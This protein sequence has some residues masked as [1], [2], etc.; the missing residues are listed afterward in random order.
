MRVMEVFFTTYPNQKKD[1]FIQELVEK[2]FYRALFLSKIMV[3]IALL[4]YLISLAENDLTIIKSFNMVFL[5]SSIVVLL[6]FV[7]GKPKEEVIDKYHM[8]LVSLVMLT[9]LFWS[10]SLLAFVPDRHELYGTYSIIILSVSSIFYLKWQIHLTIHLLS[11]SYIFTVYI[12]IGDFFLDSPVI[13]KISVLI[14]LNLFSWGISRV[15]Y[16]KNLENYN[17]TNEL[18][19]QNEEIQ[20]EVNRKTKELFDQHENQIKDIV[21]S[22]NTMLEQYTPYT[23]GH[24]ENVAD[25]SKKIAE[26]L[27]LSTYEIQETYWSAIIHDIGKLLVPLEI[28]N[29]KTY[30]TEEE[31]NIVKQHPVWA[32]NALKESESLSDLSKNVLYHHEYWDGEGYPEGLEGNDIPKISQIISIADAW[33]AMTSD[34]PYR[35]G[36][37]HDQ[38]ILLIES[39]KS[40]Q[41][42]PEVVE[43]F[44]RVVKQKEN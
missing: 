42:S 37:T 43:S 11:L 40:R 2:N 16:S 6:L 27:S 5:I 12:I 17:L 32:Y 41:F 15:I 19:S 38:A 3:G 24:C 10:S 36:L 14:F 18:Y 7:F 21:R 13:P 44:L 34:R 33:D 8:F 20:L 28:L 4:M 31:Y 9:T 1:Q 29:K 25:L 39:N 26:D 23:K 30:L 35:K 22:M